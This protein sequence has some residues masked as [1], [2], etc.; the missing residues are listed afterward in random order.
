MMTRPSCAGIATQS[1][2]KI[3]GPARTSVLVQENDVPK[4]PTQ[5]SVKNS[6]GDLPRMRRKIEKSAAATRIAKSGMTTAS[7]DRA[8]RVTHSLVAGR[9]GV[10][11]LVSV[12]TATACAPLEEMERRPE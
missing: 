4:P 9:S 5:R 3:S 2:V 1:A 8:I 11:A 12:V 10:A 6:I 7:A